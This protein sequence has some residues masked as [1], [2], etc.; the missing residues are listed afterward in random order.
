MKVMEESLVKLT[1]E[2]RGRGASNI[3]TFI[4]FFM[5]LLFILVHLSLPPCELVMTEYSKHK[6]DID[7]SRWY[8]PP[9]HTGPGGYKMCLHVFAN[10]NSDG[11]GTHVSV[12]VSLMRGEHDDKLT[13]PFRGAITV[14][15]VNQN[16][17]QDHVEY[18]A[19]F[20]DRVAAKEAVTGRVTVGIRAKSGWGKRKFISH[21]KLESTEQYLKNDCIKFRVTK[22]VVHSA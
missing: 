14:Q 13:W 11:A 7:N 2:M 22:V 16:R 12:F 4:V 3:F 9:F 1:Q 20:D 10:G 17:D 19:V 21:N 6:S 5:I 15:L 8:S 18:T